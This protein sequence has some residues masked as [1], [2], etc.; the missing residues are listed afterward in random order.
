MKFSQ[1]WS[2]IDGLIKI[3]IACI[4]VVFVAPSLL[5]PAVIR[6]VVPPIFCA[7][8]ATLLIAWLRPRYDP[9]LRRAMALL[10]GETAWLLM[11]ADALPAAMLVDVLAGFLLPLLLV[12]R[13][14]RVLVA[15]MAGGVSVAAAKAMY[16]ASTA[17]RWNTDTAA[18]ALHAV[19]RLTILLFAAGALG[20]VNRERDDARFEEELF[21]SAP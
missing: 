4:V 20:R 17:P 12:W 5:P 11:E 21:S 9:M 8:V 13:P 1:Y 6:L 14:S 2:G 16:L 10:L 3:W 7:L 15:I 19:M 18:D